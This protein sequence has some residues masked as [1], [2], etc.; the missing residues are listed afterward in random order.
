MP[1]DRDLDVHSWLIIITFMVV[2]VLVIRPIRI[3][4]PIPAWKKKTTSTPT[5]DGSSSTAPIQPAISEHYTATTAVIPEAKTW[6][7]KFPYHFTLNIGTAPVIG[8]LVLLA[9]RSIHVESI[10]NGFVGAPLSG[11][12]PYAV[13]ILF[14][15]YVSLLPWKTC[16]SFI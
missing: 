2:I 13:M 4:L 9:T 1:V 12:E 6:K 14:F 15:S 5:H 7:T 11:V 3:P 8:V 10:R 16:L